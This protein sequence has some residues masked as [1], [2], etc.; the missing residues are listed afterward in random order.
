M[1][2]PN[3]M[4]TKPAFLAAWV[5]F[6]LLLLVASANAADK[7]EYQIGAGDVI[8]VTV[9]QNPELTMETRVSESGAITF[10]LIG[11]VTVGGLAV[12]DAERKIVDMLREGGFIVQPQVN[13]LI[14]QVRSSQ[15]SVLG[16]VG[17]PGRFPLETADTKLSDMLATAGGITP[18]GADVLTLTGHRN[19]RPIRMEID[20]PA[21][22]MDGNFGQDV[23]LQGGDI[24]YVDRAPMFY[25]HGEVQRPGPYRLERGMTVHHALVQAGGMSLRGTD[26]GLRLYRRGAEGKVVEE[27]PDFDA[28]VRPNDILFV[29]KSLF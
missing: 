8:R 22:F 28:I 6:L 10:P 24:I 27:E 16:Q 15:V 13:I 14:V 25:I 17:R 5:A 20:I 19:G 3:D 21:M 4:N 18:G 26:R 29:R 7:R 11:A 23:T 12:A 1:M 2:N 9:F